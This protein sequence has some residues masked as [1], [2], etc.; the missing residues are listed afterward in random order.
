MFGFFPEDEPLLTDLFP[1]S[2]NRGKYNILYYA[3]PAV[4]EQL[5][6]AGRKEH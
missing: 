1:L 5:Q 3:D 4:L 6:P 2:L